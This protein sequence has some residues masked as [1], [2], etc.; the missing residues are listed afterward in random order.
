MIMS[1]ILIDLYKIKNPFSGLGQFSIN[2][3][4]T[5]IKYPMQNTSMEFLLP[6]GH[7]LN[8][9]KN[10]KPVYAGLQKRYFAALNKNYELW[11]SLQ[12]FPSHRP[13][14]KTK[15]LLTIHDLNF[16]I[17]K[18]KNKRRKY[19]RKLQD[20]VDRA[21]YITS[22]SNYTKKIIEENINLKGKKIEVIYNGVKILP[23]ATCDKP[24]FAGD[25][26]YFFSIGIFNKKKNFHV[27]LPLLHYFKDYNLII[28]GDNA[29]AYGREITTLAKKTNLSNRLILTGK[30]DDLTKNRLYANCEAFLFPSLAEGFGMPA[31]EAMMHGK[32][33]FL[34]KH[35]CLPEIG[36]E[37]AF[38][39]DNFEPDTMADYIKKNLN[40]FNKNRE[41]NSRKLKDYA[42][43]FSWEACIDKY[44]NLYSEILQS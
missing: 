41:E 28:A 1:K 14:K 37:N 9:N 23:V 40:G 15:Q 2:F 26:K 7:Q 8:L 25:N 36:G 4:N 44:K 42:S 24:E 22:I 12:Q 18:D 6:A 35:T 21:S 34:S 27:L 19:L 16:L 38:Y 43:K 32:P 31:I 13:N 30:I 17:E 11:H 10:I 20:N 5:L 3:A 29:T 39:F 33:V